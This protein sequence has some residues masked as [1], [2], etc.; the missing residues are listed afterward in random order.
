[1]SFM[2]TV[3]STRGEGDPEH[4]PLEN[5]PLY[6]RFYFYLLTDTRANISEIPSEGSS[7]ASTGIPHPDAKCPFIEIEMNTA[8]QEFLPPTVKLMRGGLV[9]IHLTNGHC[10]SFLAVWDWNLGVCL[11]V[12]RPRPG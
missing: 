2:L 9:A 3:R 5:I 11:G 10:I 8:T 6:R 7:K 4:T 12:S 1:M